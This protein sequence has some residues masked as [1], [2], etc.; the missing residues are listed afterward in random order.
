MTV[1]QIPMRWSNLGG[2]SMSGI[3][4]AGRK[5]SR[6]PHVSFFEAVRVE[7]RADPKDGEIKFFRVHHKKGVT[8][9][10]P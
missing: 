8:F 1:N 10:L 9:A 6:I 3:K 5:G 7:K 4:N 2:R